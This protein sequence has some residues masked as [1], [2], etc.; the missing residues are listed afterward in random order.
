MYSPYNEPS[1]RHR[2]MINEIYPALFTIRNEVPKVMFLHLSVILFGGG[3]AS[4]HAGIPPPLEAQPHGKHIP[5]EA[6]PPQE[7]HTPGKH[8][9][10]HT[11]GK[12]TP[13]P[14]RRLPLWTVR[15][16]LECI[17]VNV[18]ISESTLNKRYWDMQKEEI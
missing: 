14:R 6:P 9:R 18:F 15:I 17:L 8:P 10:K 11:P 12:H 4:V 2:K 13:P 16:L 7:A 3:S 1:K 5:P